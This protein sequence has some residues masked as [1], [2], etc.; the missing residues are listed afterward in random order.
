MNRAS[1]GSKRFFRCRWR[2]SSPPQAHSVTMWS[3]P[4]A[5]QAPSSV[6]TFA[7]PRRSSSARRSDRACSRFFSVASDAVATDLRAYCSSPSVTRWTL[8]KLPWPSRLTARRSRRHASGARRAFPERGPAAV[9]ASSTASTRCGA[10][11]AGF[12]AS[13][14]SGW[15]SPMRGSVRGSSTSP[16]CAPQ[17]PHARFLPREKRSGSLWSRRWLFFASS[18]S[19]GLVV[20]ADEEDRASSLSASDV[21][22]DAGGDTLLVSGVFVTVVGDGWR[23]LLEPLRRF[24]KV[25]ERM[26]GARGDGVCLLL[27]K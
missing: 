24:Q 4:G 13:G 7:W 19:G 5:R 17:R 1:A 3:A 23:S 25:D 10:S 11:F 12:A 20:D 2:K 15:P 8:P 16:A 14:L 9:A 22:G 18:G 6:S 27:S 26:V 21:L